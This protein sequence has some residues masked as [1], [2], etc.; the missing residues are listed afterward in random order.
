MFRTALAE[1]L[2]AHGRAD[3]AIA[4]LEPGT[5]VE[6]PETALGYWSVLAA[7]HQTTGR[8]DEA[9]EAT[10]RALAIT[11]ALGTATAA[12]RLDA[13]DLAI[14]SGELE[15]AARIAEEIRTPSYRGLL[16]ARIMHER[17]E[18]GEAVERYEEVA[19]IW[20]DNAFLRYH[21]ARALEQLGDLDRAIELYRHATR[22]D[23]TATDA[24]TRIA[25]IL[26][27]EGRV[28]DALG[29]LSLQASRGPLDLESELVF[30]RL[31]GRALPSGDLREQIAAWQRRRPAAIV[32]GLTAFASGR[33]LRGDAREALS[34][35]DF[36]D[37]GG[38][39]ANPA[40]PGF[41]REML[42]AADAAGDVSTALDALI[43]RALAHEPTSP[44]WLAVEGYAAELAGDL[45]RALDR[46]DAALAEDATLGWVVAARARVRAGSTPDE[47]AATAASLLEAAQDDRAIEEAASVVRALAEAGRDASARGLYASLLARATL[48]RRGGGG[49]SVPTWGSWGSSEATVARVAAASL[50]VGRLGRACPAASLLEAAEDVGRTTLSRGR[51]TATSSEPVPRGGSALLAELD[52]PGLL[53]HRADSGTLFAHTDAWA[54]HRGRSRMQRR[55]ASRRGSCVP[56][57]PDE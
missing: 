20:P 36:F 50:R 24:Q 22:I 49:R 8:L 21:E 47:S 52:E 31:L 17:G 9:L 18:L 38:L 46:Y 25:L 30:A 32:E 6:R 19:R 55:Y 51:R 33:R 5:A 1:R 27:A 3:E 23:A 43:D 7:L 14:R 35:V 42:R 40:G 12:D 34:F 28:R 45:D 13:A 41:V 57:G 53:A 56:G 10:L 44:A 48:R 29:I 54:R 4:L 15:R 11:E 37:P 2:E 26:E 39:V 16:E